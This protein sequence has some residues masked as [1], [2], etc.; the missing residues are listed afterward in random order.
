ML[1]AQP[2]HHLGNAFHRWTLP[3]GSPWASF[4]RDGERSIIRFPGLADFEIEA[5]GRA[6]VCRPCPGLTEATRQHLFLNQVW[7]LMLSRRGVPAF[8]GSAVAAGPGALAFL[9]AAGRGKSTLAAAL[10]VAGATHLS[11]DALVVERR[12]AGFVLFPSAPSIRLW[13]DSREALFA[14]DVAAAPAVSYTSKSR[15]LEAPGVAHATEPLPLARAFFLGDDR[16]AEVAVEP[17]SG[18]EAAAAWVAHGFILD[19][20]DS[21]TLDRHFEQVAGLAERVPCYRLD[22]P[23]RYGMLGGVR[24]AILAVA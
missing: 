3:D 7:P 22:Y 1:A 9:G 21:T 10:A 18:A 8:H 20:E 19:L 4:H 14:G 17:L 15:I 24:E 5:T 23:R 6:A 16:A 2:Q 13:S 11:D 12:G